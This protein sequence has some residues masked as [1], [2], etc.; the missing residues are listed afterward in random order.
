MPDELARKASTS[1]QAFR[2]GPDWGYGCYEQ[3][4]DALVE[5][6]EVVVQAGQLWPGAHVLDIGCG[7]GTASLIAAAAGAE[8][9]GVDPA[10]RLLQVATDKAIEVGQRIDFRQG[11]AGALPVDKSSVDIALSNFGVIFAPLASAV[12]AEIRRVLVPGGRAVF[13]AWLP[14]GALTDVSAT[15]ASLVQPARESAEPAF[16]W[17]DR[18]ALAKLFGTHDMTVDVERHTLV[19]TAPSAREYLDMQRRSHPLVKRAFDVL[20]TSGEDGAAFSRLLRILDD[21]NEG[22]TGFRTSAH[23]VVAIATREFA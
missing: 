7:A 2:P 14:E 20:E 19:I 5:A 4:A 21:G 18:S 12:A 22:D 6:A 13:S 8:V 11:D 17:H 9:V 23:Y 15:L 3:T 16:A 1:Q 10:V